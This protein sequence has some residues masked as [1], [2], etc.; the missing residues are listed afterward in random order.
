MKR[1]GIKT[2]G[3]MSGYIVARTGSGGKIRGGRQ[4]KKSGVEARLKT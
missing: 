3:Q 4:E 2:V 1:E